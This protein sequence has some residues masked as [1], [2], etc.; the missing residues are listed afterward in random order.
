MKKRLYLVR[1]GE[2]IKQIG[3]PALSEKGKLQAKAT[4][5]YFRKFPIQ[6]VLSSPALRTQQTAEFIAHSLGLDVVLNK[7]L[8]E[9]ANWGQDPLQSSDDFLE[10]WQR[11]SS[12]RDWLPP[13]GD[14][15]RMAGERLR[16]AASS[17]DTPENTVLVTHG[18]IITDFLRN[19]FGDT[20]ENNVSEC[21]ITI[22]EFDE[23]TFQYE[24]IE[25]AS[26]KHL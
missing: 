26:T 9:R 20:F 7:L 8:H 2:K 16:T 21:S 12:E 4:G 10:M 23:A 6:K 1:H 13:I 14:S 19:I 15:S 5:E 11:A 17:Y 24:L 18:G 3:D 22:V 25:F